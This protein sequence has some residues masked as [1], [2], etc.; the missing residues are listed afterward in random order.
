MEKGLA[1]C[2]AAAALLL[3]G[4]ANPAADGATATHGT[5]STTASTTAAATSGT[6]TAT[7]RP[8]QTPSPSAAP[9]QSPSTAESRMSIRGVVVDPA[10]HPLSSTVTILETNTSQA[11]GAGGAFR[12]DN[13]RPDVYFL[14]ARSEGFRPRTLSVTPEA[15]KKAVVFQLEANP[16]DAAYNETIHFKGTLECALEALILSPSCDTLITDPK[17]LNRPDLAQ[18]NSTSTVVVDV[19]DNWKTVVTDVVFDGSTQ[20]LLDGLRVTVQGTHNQSALG[21]YQQ[22]GRFNGPHPFTFRLEPGASYDEGTGGP[23]PQNTTAF[24]F[25]VYPQSLLWH[26]TPCLPVPVPTCFLGV[27]FGVD[28]QFDLYITTF[29]GKPAPDGFT[30]R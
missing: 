27:G 2:L 18:F 15:S 6:T 13:L 28:V 29:Y 7:A 23:V 24:R 9:T 16:S 1:L 17:G 10:F 22:Y 3:A 11:T 25:N 8:T 19:Q 20:P 4:C 26:A 12:F 30:L 5:S 14:T 21:T